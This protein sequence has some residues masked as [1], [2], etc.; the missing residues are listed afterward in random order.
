VA[1]GVAFWAPVSGSAHKLLDDLLGGLRSGLTYGGG[2][3][4][5][6]LQRKA[7][8]MQVTPIICRKASRVRKVRI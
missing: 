4:I 3:S 1:E 5:K 2:R 7:E 8:F 6:E